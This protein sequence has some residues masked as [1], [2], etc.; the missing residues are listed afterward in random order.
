MKKKDFMA[1]DVQA[2]KGHLHQMI[3]EWYE[4]D[5]DNR[6][7][8]VILGDRKDD[9]EAGTASCFFAGNG[10]LL[11]DSLANA[12]HNNDALKTMAAMCA[13]GPIGLLMAKHHNESEEE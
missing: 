6:C 12:M 11:V 7:A 2:Q 13:V 8:I 5:S 9:K 3:D 10:K 1:L 4:Q